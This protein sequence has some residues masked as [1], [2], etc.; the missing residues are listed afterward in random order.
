MRQEIRYPRSAAAVLLEFPPRA[1][2]LERILLE[3]VH[4]REALASDE[5]LRD[6]LAV[7]LL[8]LRLVVEHLELAWTAGHEEIDD[9]L[10]L[11]RK[12]SRP[13][14]HRLTGLI[15]LGKQAT[16]AQKLGERQLAETNPGAAEKVPA[17]F[18]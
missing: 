3:G 7:I 14:L 8:Q 13:G 6:R 12:V 18:V 15:G 4:E 11:R 2:D 17:G 9:V 1:E 16:I 5:R 10:H